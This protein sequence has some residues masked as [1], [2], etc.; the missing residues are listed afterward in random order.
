M[1]KKYKFRG[2]VFKCEPHTIQ[3]L[4]YALALNN[5]S[6]RYQEVKRNGNKK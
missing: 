4:N 3:L 2:K 1:K 6:D 5:A